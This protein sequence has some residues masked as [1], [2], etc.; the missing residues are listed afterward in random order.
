[1]PCLECTAGFHFECRSPE[2]NVCCCPAVGENFVGLVEPTGRGKD[3]SEMIDPLST[4]RKQAAVLKPITEGMT[5]EWAG[6]KFAGG[7]IYPIVGC[8]PDAGNLAKHI[9]HGPDKDTTN[10][11]DLNLHRICSKCHNRWHSLNDPS[12]GARPPAGTPF[13]PTD[14][15]WRLHDN[16][17]KATVDEHFASE[18]WFNTPPKRRKNDYGTAVRGSSAG[19]SGAD[20]PSKLSATSDDSRTD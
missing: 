7:G 9:H 11:S 17:T 13:V 18:L 8:L 14:E 10:N 1:M 16:S 2:N 20:A 15:K 5:C 6:L 4:G 3:P 19:G 12:Y